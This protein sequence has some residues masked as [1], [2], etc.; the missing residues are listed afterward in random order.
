MN[1]PSI[2]TGNQPIPKFSMCS[3]IV[4]SRKFILNS[5]LRLLSFMFESHSIFRKFHAFSEKEQSNE[6]NDD[7]F[8]VKIYHFIILKLKFS[9]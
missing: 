6:I 9:T 2:Q 5:L 4:K 8:E 7:R 1:F 3:L